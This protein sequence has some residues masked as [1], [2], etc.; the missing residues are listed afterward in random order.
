MPSADS[1]T[2]VVPVL[3]EE[4]YIRRAIESLVPPGD[5]RDFEVIVLDGGSSDHTRQIVAEMAARDGRIRLVA[6][7]ARLQSAAVNKGVRIA[8]ATSDVIVRA[9]CHSIYPA[10]FVMRAVEELRSRRVASVVVPVHTAGISRFQRAVAAAQNSRLCNGGSP[11]RSKVESRHVEHGHHAAF[12]R[13]AFMSV[14]GYDETFSHNEDAE[15]DVRL[16]RSGAKIWLCSDLAVTYFPRK[17][18][19]ALASQYFNYG[20]GRARTMFKHSRPPKLRQALPLAV[21]AMNLG[22]ATLGMT[23]GWIFLAPLL[24]Y[25]ALCLAWGGIL[26]ASERDLACLASGFAA[27]VMHHSWAG[28]FVY[29]SAQ[30]LVASRATV[31]AA[32]PA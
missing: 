15:L 22:S 3:D 28:G 27:A 7:E 5:R 10:G 11:H 18:V 21:L 14:D 12:D 17:S 23:A 16:I 9:D 30:Q 25:S 4:A 26:A 13:C 1:V 20:S 8:R 29:R 19:G 6:N 32:R 2:I 31:E 24:A